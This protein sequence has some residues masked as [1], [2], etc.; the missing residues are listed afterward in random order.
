LA[1]PDVFVNKTPPILLIN[2]GQ[3]IV[4]AQKNKATALLVKE[5]PSVIFVGKD[6]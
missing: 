1:E 4:N 5:L 2:T 6:R 3:A